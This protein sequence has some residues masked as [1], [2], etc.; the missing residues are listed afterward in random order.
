MIHTKSDVSLQELVDQEEEQARLKAAA[1]F[2]NAPELQQPRYDELPDPRTAGLVHRDPGTGSGTGS[3]NRR[4]HLVSY[5][6]DGSI[7][8]VSDQPPS[9]SSSNSGESEYSL[10][11]E[12]GELPAQQQQRR[13]FDSP[14][15]SQP[16]QLRS[17]G[18]VSP[19]QRPRGMVDTEG[20]L[21]VL[22][23]PSFEEWAHQRAWDPPNGT[24]KP[25]SE[26]IPPAPAPVA[27]QGVPD[28]DW[29]TPSAT[30]LDRRRRVGSPVMR[31]PSP[32]RDRTPRNSN[33]S[34]RSGTHTPRASL[35]KSGRL[36]FVAPAD[37][38][39]NSIDALEREVN[40]LSYDKKS[41]SR[42]GLSI[43]GKDLDDPDMPRSAPAVKTD[44][45]DIGIPE[46]RRPTS[47]LPSVTVPSPGH[48]STTKLAPP[49]EGSPVMNARRSPE[50]PP[51]SEL[52]KQ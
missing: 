42:V 27:S 52:R 3:S 9:P 39:R 38:S 22:L 8:R 26:P 35:P 51:R 14:S 13:Q 29:R 4:I 36:L 32:G 43:L 11:D 20:R 30:L 50:P 5:P 6:S 12:S 37:V 49:P 16:P 17:P 2:P 48:P 1:L 24:E 41:G 28:G 19:M 45:G 21:D 47:L 10:P 25:S 7:P 46:T 33:L 23:D 40:G 31:T 18:R 44:F 34:G 15:L